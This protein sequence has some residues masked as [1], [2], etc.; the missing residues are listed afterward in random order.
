MMAILA[1][2]VAA[3][4]A[5]QPRGQAATPGAGDAAK[6]KQD[7]V[8]YS[9]FSC[10]GRS[11]NGAE[12]GPRLDASRLSFETFSSYVRQPAGSMP[13]FRMQSQI[14]D[15]QLAD[16]YAFLK[17]VPPPPD[18]KTIPLLNND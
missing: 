6:G 16:V 7:F 11:G 4:R 9:C 12:D 10:H 3:V 1:C 17:S 15:S 2:P 8:T 14:S 5:Q 13:P 18:P